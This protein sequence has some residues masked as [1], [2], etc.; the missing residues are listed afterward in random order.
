MIENR[1]VSIGISLVALLLFSTWRV[2]TAEPESYLD[3]FGKY[4]AVVNKLNRLIGAEEPLAAA[5]IARLVSR[6]K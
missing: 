2:A 3:A 6:I 4:S 5:D 1:L